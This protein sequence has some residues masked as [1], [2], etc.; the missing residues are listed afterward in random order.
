MK[1]QRQKPKSSKTERKSQ[2]HNP[3]NSAAEFAHER[4]LREQ[5]EHESLGGARTDCMRMRG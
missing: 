1:T 3:K 2:Q 5:A 4:E